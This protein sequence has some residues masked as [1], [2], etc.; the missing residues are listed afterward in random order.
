MADAADI[1][2]LKVTLRGTKPLIWRR[3]RVRSDVTL[4]K[5]HQIL[6]TVMGWTDS[7]LHQFIVGDTYY[8]PDDP[9]LIGV[10]QDEKKV[11]LSE[12]LKKPRGRIVYEYDFGDGWTHDV[13]LEQ[14]VE[15]EPGAKYPY[16]VKGEGACPPEDCGGVQGY[17]R[18]LEVL[19]KP[20]HPEHQEMQEWV[21][22]G[23]SPDAF[24]RNEVNI[25][26][27]GG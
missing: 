20:D 26:L 15:F 10:R 11:R 25:K 23:F 21:G 2:E 13:V 4:L 27:H 19:S 5:L 9:K 22:D 24:D 12:I 3:F 1:Y 7:H 18:L 17:Y 16:V 14:V 8:G 6:Q